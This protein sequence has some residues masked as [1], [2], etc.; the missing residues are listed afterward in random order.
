MEQEAVTSTRTG[1]I[2]GKEFHKIEKLIAKLI[3]SK[4]WRDSRSCMLGAGYLT[5]RDEDSDYYVAEVAFTIPSLQMEGCAHINYGNLCIAMMGRNDDVRVVV[6]GDS[7]AID[8]QSFIQ[9]MP[10]EKFT[11]I[12]DVGE[13]M[14]ETF[15]IPR[16]IKDVALAM[17]SS[18]DLRDNLRGVHISLNENSLTASNGHMLFTTEL[19]PE[20]NR[21]QCEEKI[22]GILSSEVVNL[23]AELESPYA[24]FF[25]REVGEGESK[26][27]GWYMSIAADN[28]SILTKLRDSQFPEYKQLFETKQTHTFTVKKQCLVNALARIKKH[29][30]KNTNPYVTC[31][32]K[33]G[34]LVKKI[35]DGEEIRELL[36]DVE[37]VTDLTFGFD[38]NYMLTV[39]KTQ[40]KTIEFKCIPNKK[41][42]CIEAPFLFDKGTVKILLMPTRVF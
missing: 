21:L 41:D 1:K 39:A 17:S 6:T 23:V 38:L 8:N 14:S 35:I 26:T 33:N 29:L 9:V 20:E 32:G 42:G 13:A 10:V 28:V 19:L 16:T 12:Q 27:Y 30:L 31:H 22:E 4:R 15:A 7:L 3:P 11:F 5:I 36:V 40:P 25:R 24:N 18:D 2:N 34:L 37:G